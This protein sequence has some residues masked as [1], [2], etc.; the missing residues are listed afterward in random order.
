MLTGTTRPGY[1]P[2]LAW[3]AGRQF[4]GRTLLIPLAFMFLH[5]AVINLA[6]VVYSL[7]LYLIRSISS[8]GEFNGLPGGDQLTDLLLQHYPR[9]A[10]IQALVLIPVYAIFLMLQQKRDP[11]SVWLRRPQAADVLPALAMILGALGVTNLL[12]ALL[13]WLGQH[14]PLVGDQLQ[15]YLEQANAYS[16][17]GGYF[18]L[19]LGISIMAPISE[20]LL[21]RGIIQGELRK[22]LP[23]WLAVVIQ[24]LLF[25]LFHM[26]PVQVLYVLTPALLL[27]AAYAWSRSLWV[28]IIMHIVFNFM[29]SVVPAWLGEDTFLTGL[30]SLVEIGFILV[31]IPAALVMA[32]R[33][34]RTIRS[35]EPVVQL[36]PEQPPL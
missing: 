25:A 7:L 14:L 24:A 5:L 6:A 22:A 11:R 13:Q 29:G 34:R 8:P 12:F 9:I 27:G 15:D 17:D 10:V 21:F 2:A 3:P 19:I 35:A 32:S 30:V 1:D 28:P 16:P 23:E 33:Y 4:R 18:W 31:A 26:Q 36:P 20:E